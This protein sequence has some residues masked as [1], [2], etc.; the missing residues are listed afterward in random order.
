METLL[1]AD[2]FF[3]VTTVAVVCVSAAIVVIAVYLTRIL[4][5][6]FKISEKAKS[7][8]DNIV[9][10]VR[11]LRTA[12]REEGSKLKSISELLTRFAPRKKKAKAK[13]P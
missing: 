7:E 9:A 1:K 12:I 8:A 3:F 13:E 11:E 2:V 5:Q 4:K 10:D 6:V